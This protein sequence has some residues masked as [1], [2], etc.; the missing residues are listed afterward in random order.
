MRC[1]ICGG[2]L[3]DVSGPNLS[4]DAAPLV[5]EK[6]AR[7][8]W[9]EELQDGLRRHFRKDHRDFGDGEGLQLLYDMAAKKAATRD[10]RRRS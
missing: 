8:Y 3:K 9:P 6:D 1:L 5:C 7:A 2:P 4:I 10:V